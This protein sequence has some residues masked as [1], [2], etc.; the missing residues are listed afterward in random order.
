MTLDDPDCHEFFVPETPV[1]GKKTLYFRGFFTAS[2][3][4][5]FRRE[6]ERFSQ[7]A[8]SSSSE[9]L[10]SLISTGR[11]AAKKIS[12]FTLREKVIKYVT[13]LKNSR[14]LRILASTLS[15]ARKAT[16]KRA[17]KI[18]LVALLK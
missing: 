2:L 11:T 12:T 16:E 18:T 13:V 3:A 10:D 7:K 8:V 1:L 9:R 17:R 15:S 14:L 6:R 5:E 4:A